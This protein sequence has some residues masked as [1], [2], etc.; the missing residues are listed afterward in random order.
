[1]SGEETKLSKNAKRKLKAEEKQKRKI[2]KEKNGPPADFE[3]MRGNKAPKPNKSFV[4]YYQQIVP[5]DQWQVTC[6]D[7]EARTNRA[8]LTP[9]IAAVRLSLT[10]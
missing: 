4:A 5:A 9:R 8:F 2:A 1:M 7:A 3:K 6:V 10:A